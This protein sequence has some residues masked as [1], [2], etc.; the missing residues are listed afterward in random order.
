MKAKT[1]RNIKI[2]IIVALLLVL[3]ILA[4]VYF[5]MLKSG[6][7]I[8]SAKKNTIGKIESIFSIYGPGRGRFP[9]FVK[10]MSVATDKD[11]NIYVSD[12]GN[13]RIC[14]FDR[15]GDFLFEFGEIGVAKPIAGGKATWAPGKFSFPYGIDVEDETGKIFVADMVNGRVQ[16]FDNTGKFLDWFPKEPVKAGKHPTDLYPLALD[17]HK[18]KVYVCNPF[19]IMIFDTSGKLVQAIGMPGTGNSEFDRPNGI[20]VAE[21]G[22]FYVSDSNN[23]RVQAFDKD[24]KFRWVVGK[25]TADG[26]MA[27]MDPNRL[28]GIPRNLKV[29]PDGNVY[30]VDGF[31]FKIKVYSPEGKLLA[32]MGQRGVEDG[33][34]NFPNGIAITQ[35]N[36]IYIADK[37]NNRVQAIRLNGFE[38]EKD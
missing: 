5:I 36:I 32:S 1:K 30:I 38:I 17:V 24:G 18:G 19:Q 11:N 27:K 25:P 15:D 20:A 8:I 9:R 33:Y 12:S 2:G 34:F 4:Y 35:D 29:G 3:A 14:V 10:P 31:D 6:G 21:D 28:F 16:I 7:G 37:E 23:L 22:S 26:P 13:N